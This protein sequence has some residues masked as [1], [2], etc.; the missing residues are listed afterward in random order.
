MKQRKLNDSAVSKTLPVIPDAPPPDPGRAVVVTFAPGVWPAIG[1][2]IVVAIVDVVFVVIVS[3]MDDVVGDDV[4]V[5]HA[6]VIS[7]KKI[8]ILRNAKQ[9]RYVINENI[10]L[11]FTQKEVC[12]VVVLQR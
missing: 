1:V 3:F 12:F 4:V 2:F 5:E 9:S 7:K 8:Y 11:Y 10:P 6:P